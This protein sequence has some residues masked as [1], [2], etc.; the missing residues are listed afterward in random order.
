MSSKKLVSL[1]EATAIGAKRF[2]TGV[3]CTN[4]HV[5]ERRV[6]GQHCVECHRI[7]AKRQR[8]RAKQVKK[9]GG[10]FD[11]AS[12]RQL[13]V[14]TLL[15]GWPTLEM[16]AH[17]YSLQ[18]LQAAVLSGSHRYFTGEICKYGHIDLRRA[19]SGACVAC[20][21]KKR[22]GSDDPRKDHLFSAISMSRSAPALPEWPV[23]S[24]E[25]ALAQNLPRYYARE[26]CKNGHMGPRYVGNL[27]CALCSSK[28]NRERYASD[29]EFRQHRIGYESERNRRPEVRKRRLVQMR[30]YNSRPEVRQRLLR[31]IKENPDVKLKWNLKTRLRIALKIHQ[32]KKT[33]KL[34]TILGCSIVE[35]KDH[36]ARQFTDGMTWE[37][38]GE[39]ELD[40]IVPLSS[41]LTGPEVVALFHHTNTRPLWKGP[42]R[43]K[44]QNRDFLI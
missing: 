2:F 40:H 15:D 17:I 4:G 34:Q 14:P 21:W 43:S 27:E 6:V 28:R 38:H 39:W 22:H 8:L 32:H 30:E 35:F 37:N 26:I 1:L 33:S 31:S 16:L 12:A 20:D 25:D 10:D 5:A 29:L 42:N 19:A 3:P 36:I 7:N 11:Q 44:G 24:R 23:I 41:G 18:P 13:A 9:D